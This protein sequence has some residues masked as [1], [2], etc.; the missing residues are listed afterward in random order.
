[1]LRSFSSDNCYQYHPTVTS[2]KRPGLVNCR[3][4]NCLS[5][6][7]CRLILAWNEGDPSVTGEAPRKEP[8]MRTLLPSLDVIIFYTW[9]DGHTT[10]Y[11]SQY[12]ITLCRYVSRS[13]N[14]F[15]GSSAKRQGDIFSVAHASQPSYRDSNALIQ[16]LHVRV[17]GYM[18]TLFVTYGPKRCRRFDLTSA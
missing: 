9:T 14:M 4:V 16:F 2:H 18:A 13:Q 5:S 1:M 7:L 12:N 3:H 11:C 6:S 17:S 15:P 8:A 10:L